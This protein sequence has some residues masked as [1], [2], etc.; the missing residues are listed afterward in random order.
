MKIVL[1]IIGTTAVIV[2]LIRF[3]PFTLTKLL[4][5]FVTGGVFYIACKL[6][7][8]TQKGHILKDGY[9]GWGDWSKRALLGSVAFLTLSLALL[10]FSF[11]NPICEETGVPF[12][13]RCEKFIEESSETNNRISFNLGGKA[14]YPLFLAVAFIAGSAAARIEHIRRIGQN[15]RRKR[16]RKY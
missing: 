3:W 14:L 15:D 8:D 12:Y 13:G 1:P 9:K 11:N 4:S 10:F 6:G 7:R 2:Q 5:A 16:P